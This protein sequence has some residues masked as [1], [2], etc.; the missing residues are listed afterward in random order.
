[1]L[2]TTVIIVIVIVMSSITDL[3]FGS[4]REITVDESSMEVTQYDLS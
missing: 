3:A 4:Q 1:M 2:A